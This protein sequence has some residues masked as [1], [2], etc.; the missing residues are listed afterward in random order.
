[1]PIPSHKGNCAVAALSPAVC[2]RL[3]V[4]GTVALVI[5]MV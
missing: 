3:D 2:L 5:Y 4:E 1:M